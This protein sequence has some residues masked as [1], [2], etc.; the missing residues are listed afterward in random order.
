MFGSIS[1]CIKTLLGNLKNYLFKELIR[2]NLQPENEEACNDR[3]NS[4]IQKCITSKI[5]LH[6]NNNKLI[7]I[8]KY[9]IIILK[10]LTP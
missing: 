4:S 9:I 3:K 2:Y 1:K 10:P 6:N 7:I 8:I 5:K